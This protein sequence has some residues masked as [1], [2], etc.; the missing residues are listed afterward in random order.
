MSQPQG[1][2]KEHIFFKNKQTDQVF[3]D[4]KNVVTFIKPTKNAFNRNP[5][6]FSQF[7][8]VDFFEDYVR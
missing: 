2:N 4:A 1:G 6:D 3:S 5:S 7:Q 8:Q